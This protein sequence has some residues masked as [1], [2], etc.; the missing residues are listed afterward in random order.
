M[1]LTPGIRPVRRLKVADSVA[2]QLERL[3]TDGGFALGDRLPAERVLAEQFGVGRSSMREALRMVEALGLVRTDHGVGVFVV[4]PEKQEPSA[5]QLLLFDE[6]TVGDLF[7]V[8]LPMEEKAASLAAR[9]V[10]PATATRLQE[11][12]EAASD[13]HLSDAQFSSS[14]VPCTKRSR[15]PPATRSSWSW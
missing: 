12:L 13:P 6:F 4:R 2:A 11:L 8:R 10:T 3:I 5:S 7:E 1:S 15:R 14:T 9:R